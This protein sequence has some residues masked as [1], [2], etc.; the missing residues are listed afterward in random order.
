MVCLLPIAA[1]AQT[2]PSQGPMIVERVHSG[3]LVAPDFKIT[4]VDGKTSELAGGYAG[5]LTGDKIFIGGGGYWLANQS[6]DREMA[7]GGLI[8]Q[9]LARTDERFGF[10]ARGLV[11][12]GRA[13]LSSS[14]SDILKMSDGDRR[15]LGRITQDDL[16]R[17]RLVDSRIRFR[18][19]FFVAEPEV[20]LLVRLSKRMRLTGGAGYRFTGGEGRNDNRL[21]GAVG[22]VGLQIGGGS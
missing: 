15:S 22:S 2:T 12:G 1:T 9:W 21:H 3:F 18:E 10:S 7:Y 19:E 5:V 8:V 17:S 11:G 20:G 14:L 6:S 13:T 16:N 4:E